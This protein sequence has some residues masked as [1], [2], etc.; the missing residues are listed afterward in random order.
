VNYRVIYA[1]EV[2][3]EL[4]ESIDWYYGKQHGLGARFLKNVK[5]QLD[6]IEKNPYG[7]AIRY[8]EIRCSKVKTFPYLIHFKIEEEIKTVKVI[9]VLNT[10]R[11]PAIWISR[12]K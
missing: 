12:N 1:P 2:E 11:N 5:E 4:Q 7:V 9:A 10:N 6:Y 3:T 8:D